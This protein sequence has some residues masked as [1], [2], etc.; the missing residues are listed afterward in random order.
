MYRNFSPSYSD[1]PTSHDGIIAVLG[2]LI[3]IGAAIGLIIGVMEAFKKKP[4]TCPDCRP[5]LHPNIVERIDKRSA[6]LRA[7]ARELDARAERA[8]A[9]AAYDDFI[10]RMKG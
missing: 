2:I 5:D 6:R 7:E 4:C 3:L 9:Q 1:F 8:V 10:K